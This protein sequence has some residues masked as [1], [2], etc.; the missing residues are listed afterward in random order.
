M[1]R[2]ST[3]SL[4]HIGRLLDGRNMATIDE[5]LDAV[6]LRS[7]RD[8]HYR[9]YLQPARGTDRRGRG[10]PGRDDAALKAMLRGILSDRGLADADARRA[11]LALLSGGIP[12]L[13]RRD[14]RAPATWSCRPAARALGRIDR[15]GV[16]GLTG[17][18]VDEIAAMAAPWPTLAS[19]PSRR[20]PLRPR[21]ADCS[22]QPAPEGG[23][24][25]V[26]L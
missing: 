23:P 12:W 25:D 21:R 24:A 6:A 3:A 26:P 5:M 4:A 16:R 14:S 9:D 7:A 10:G 17:V 22:P 8:Q 15:D 18:S 20:A 2:L 1:R 11:A 19:S 13:S